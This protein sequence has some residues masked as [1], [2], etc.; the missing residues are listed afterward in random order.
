MKD[1]ATFVLLYFQLTDISNT[2]EKYHL[3]LFLRI[4]NQ[5]IQTFEVDE[6]KG[7]DEVFLFML[8]LIALKR[9]RKN[10]SNVECYNRLKTDKKV[11]VKI[12]NDRKGKIFSNIS[13]LFDFVLL[14]C[15]FYLQI[16]GT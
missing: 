13:L 9:K 15:I 5:Y 11:F 4:T 1:L 8:K 12:Y 7:D 16:I 10:E 3:G 14:Y 2:M 6:F